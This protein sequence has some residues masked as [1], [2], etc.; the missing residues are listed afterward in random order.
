MKINYALLADLA[1][2][3]PD[4]KVNILG[5]GIDQL[6][7]PEFPI[8]QPVLTLVARIEVAA[9]ECD[10]DHRFQVLFWDQD[11]NQLPPTVDGHFTAQRNPVNPAGISNIQLAIMM[12][13][14]AIPRAGDYSFRIMLDDREEANLPLLVRSSPQRASA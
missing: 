10:K 4:G 8:V 1:Q 13:Q 12:S 14:V 3:T 11:G 5:G 6:M 7:A 2:A 9:S